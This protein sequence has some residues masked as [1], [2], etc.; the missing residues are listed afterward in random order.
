MG[1]CPAVFFLSFFKFDVYSLSMFKIFKLKENG[2][3]VKT[4]IIAGLSTFMTMA[5]ILAV[6]PL[7]LS[8]CGMDFTKVFAATAIASA[9]SCFVMGFYAN[10]PFALSASMGVNAMFAY[11]IC[12]SMGYS[13]QWALTATL[14]EGIIFILLTVTNLREAIVNSIPPNLKKAIGAGVGLFV[15]YIGLKNGNVIV[16]DDSTITAIN[17]HWFTGTPLLTILGVIIT[18]ILMVR[19]VRG[20]I[21]IGILIITLLGIPMGETKYAGGSFLPASPYFCEFSFSE[22]FTNHKTLSDF[23]IITVTLLYV[24]MFNT[25]GTLIA[26]AGKSNMIQK[27]GSIPRT[28]EALMADAVGTTVGAVFGTSTITTFVESSTGV[29]EGGRTGLTTI[30]V[31]ILFLLSLFI[32]PIFGSIPSA[33]TAAALILVGGMMIEPMKDIDYS[34]YTELIPAFLTILMMICT[35]SISDGILFGILSYVLLKA[36]TGRIKQL[37]LMT[38]VVAGLFVIR[39]IIGILS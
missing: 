7:I 18:A 32:E 5:Y 26:C 6:N 15:A 39:I 20:A 29:A 4:E 21:L 8:A 12:N 14:M 1:K 30:V 3:D 10:L 23:I 38:W 19:N 2:S 16:S 35:S 13:W 34:D 17:S 9:I 37:Q 28:R 25:V 22:I 24:D 27:D 11:T 31:G 33:A 36:F